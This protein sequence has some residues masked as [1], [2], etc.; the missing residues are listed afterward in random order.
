MRLHRPPGF[1]ASIVLVMLAASVAR[2]DHEAPAPE[3]SIPRATVYSPF[4]GY[5]RAFTGSDNNVPLV[6]EQSSFTGAKSSP[7][8]GAT[9]QGSWTWVHPG[10]WNAGVMGSLEH[11]RY[12][13]GFEPGTT[14]APKEYNLT[15]VN[16]E[17]FAYRT[18][19]AFGRPTRLEASYDFRSESFP[20]ENEDG[21][22]HHRFI[23]KGQS[24][25]M[26]GL[27]VRLGYRFVLYDY[28]VDF[29]D[30][31]L[32]NRD[33]VFQ[34]IDAEGSYN[35]PK[36]RGH[37]SVTYQRSSADA[38]G[39][40]FDYKGNAFKVRVDNKLAPNVWTDISALKDMRTYDGFVTADP[41]SYLSAA[42]RKAVDILKGQGKLM[43]RFA[44]NWVADVNIK[45][46]KID[47][48]SSWFRAKRTIGGA[49]ITYSFSGGRG[50]RP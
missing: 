26:P 43:W 18:M 11:I 27:A 38:D 23:F 47:A 36:L 10:G 37:V 24:F 39:R 32:N 4:R 20:G 2:A 40:N 17:L 49:G 13:K 14:N 29:P 8:L 25:P 34:R 33:G 44:P 41:Y 30:P 42:T 21:S 22:G 28:N 6:A 9:A 15:V 12:S 50:G 46:T 7:F 19:T 1:A 31:E 5:V 45:T 48:E 3:L 16:P 35:V